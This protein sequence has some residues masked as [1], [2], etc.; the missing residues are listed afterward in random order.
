[1]TTGGCIAVL[2]AGSSSIKFAMYEPGADGDLLLRGQVERIGQAPR[3][4]A[5]DASGKILAE[6]NLSDAKAD[7]AA[8]TAEIIAMR[9]QLLGERLV[10]A[11]GHR[12]VHGGTEFSAPVLIDDKVLAKLAEL[13]P[14]APLHQ[15][16]NLAPIRAIAHAAPRLPQVA[17][18]DT[19]FHRSQPVL[20]QVFALPREITAAGV[21][22]Y[23]FH[24]LSYDYI[25]TRLQETEPA[26]ARARLVIAHLGN[27]ASLCAVR[28]G[29]S[30]ASTMGFTAV[31]GLMM[32]TRTG[33]IDPGV[34][35]YLM[36]ERGLDATGI[37][38]LLY[39]RS[40]LLGVSGIASDMRTLR[41]SKASEAREAIDLFTYRI[42]REIGSMAAALGGV[43]ALVFTAGI[44]EH[45]AATRAEVITG[46]DWLG[47]A[48]DEARNLV[49]QG[50]ITTDA[51]R[52]AG[53]VVPTDEERMISR[54]TSGFI[55]THRRA[56]N[57]P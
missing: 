37:E 13:A 42:V 30:V 18:F 38:D 23:G 31:D 12:V 1:M 39:R 27:G 55:A 11:V 4:E 16:H 35:L 52:V 44:G 21:R 48:L 6:H 33:A 25:V 57:P 2:N 7:H 10:L 43:D 29:K 8:A 49:G 32:G 46:C 14:L 28:D 19:A 3:L 41:Q 56:T 22:R 45:D 24:G 50:L 15:P 9:R 40:G 53:W 5:R 34:L 26:L 47:I 51:S 54:Y 36:Q 20:A 17:C